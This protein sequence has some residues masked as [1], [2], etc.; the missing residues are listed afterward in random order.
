MFFNYIF[1]SIATGWRYPCIT[2]WNCFRGYR[3]IHETLAI[4]LSQCYRNLVTISTIVT[5]SKNGFIAFLI[6]TLHMNTTL[7]YIFLDGCA[8]VLCPLSFWSNNINVVH[9]VNS[10][11]H[12]MNGEETTTS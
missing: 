9:K 11:D 12:V 8:V 4:Q 7:A 3:D 5:P 1:N 10:I 2:V 6:Q